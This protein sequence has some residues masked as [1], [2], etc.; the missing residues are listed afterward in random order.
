MLQLGESGASSIPGHVEDLV[1]KKGLQKE[2]QS[3]R[4][5]S[6]NLCQGHAEPQEEGPVNVHMWHETFF[7]REW[8]YSHL[9]SSSLHHLRLKKQ[10]QLDKDLIHCNLYHGKAFQI[11]DISVSKH[12]RQ[13]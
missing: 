4:S 10:N 2:E 7:A 13:R 9:S 12:T 3:V 6:P 1:P 11:S 5:D 8:L